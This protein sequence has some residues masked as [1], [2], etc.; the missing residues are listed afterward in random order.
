MRD[1][2]NQTAKGFVEQVVALAP[3]LDGVRGE[4]LDRFAKA[5][6]PTTRV[7]AWK[8]TNLRG[9]DKLILGPAPDAASVA[10]DAIPTA[11]DRP[12]PRL[13]F[14][15]GQFRADLSRTDGLPDGA[16]LEPL[17]AGTAAPATGD[18]PFRALNSALPSDGAALRIGPA[19][20]LDRPVELVFIAA[21][22][23]DKAALWNP[24]ILIDIA[25]GAEATVVEHHV[26]ANAGPY[27]SNIAADVKVGAGAR[28]HHYKLQAE[29][30]DA[31]HLA[32]IATHLA[33]DAV[34][35]TFVLNLGARLA[36][37]EARQVLDGTGIEARVS[38]AYAIGGNQV[39]DITTLIDH[40]RPSCT[41]REVVKGVIDGNARA[42]FQ[43]KIV[44]RPDAQK[45]DGY[46]LNRALLLS[47]NAEINSKPELEIYADDVKCSHG[48]TAGELDEDQM[49]YLRARGI[50]RDAARVLLIG[51]FLD[52]A[53]D[54]IIDEDIR[55]HFRGRAESWMG[56]R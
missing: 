47:D 28:L 27:V 23:G 6:L 8:F 20:K 26:G 30:L 19:V 17:A 11:L 55:A 48:A 18:D 43:G 1:E 40:A 31:W 39:S 5:G 42:V 2:Q 53:L 7:E 52:E 24:R 51:A 34:Y 21:S 33:Q 16:V 37:H 46:Q 54:E 13:V 50:P 3:A 14:V 12:G 41:S 25:D 38:G 10:V 29:S 4:G 15:A 44:V 9:L 45:T 56:R 35:D 32:N 36:R 22:A 49:F